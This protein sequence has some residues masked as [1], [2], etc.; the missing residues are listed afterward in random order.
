MRRSRDEEEHRGPDV[1]L[2]LG[3]HLLLDRDLVAAGVDEQ[4]ARGRRPA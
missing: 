3:D 4:G 1:V 2:D